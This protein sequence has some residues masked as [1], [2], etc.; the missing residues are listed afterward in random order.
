MPTLSILGLISVIW[1]FN[2]FVYVWLATGAGP[3]TYTN[4]LA[5]EVYIRAF[6]DLRIGYSSAIG[7]VMAVVMAAFGALYFRFFGLMDMQDK[8]G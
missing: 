5:T 1:T 8:V 7:V 2:N 3:G 4:V 6:I